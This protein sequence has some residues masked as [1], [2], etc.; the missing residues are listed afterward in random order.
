MNLFIILL[1]EAVE[2]NIIN[3]DKLD[4]TDT[5]LFVYKEDGGEEKPRLSLKLYQSLS[6]LKCKIEF[7]GLD[8]PNQNDLELFLAFLCGKHPEA[9][10]IGSGDELKRLWMLGIKT[11]SDLKGATASTPRGRER[12]KNIPGNGNAI[13]KKEE[14]SQIPK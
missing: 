1:N 9:Q 13:E 4:E 10:V 6:V 5:I 7:I 8:V 2:N 14:T 3:S 11:Y 12:K